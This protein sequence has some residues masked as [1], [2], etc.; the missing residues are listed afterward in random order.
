MGRP[1]AVVRMTYAEYLAAE[2]AADVRHEYL[3][4]DVWAM[5][6]G[7]IEHGGLAVALARAGHR[8]TLV[9]ADESSQIADLFGM[10]AT[11]GLTEVLRGRLEMRKAIQSV[12]DLPD[13]ALVAAGH[14]LDSEIDELI[15]RRATGREV[16]TAAAARGFRTLADDAISRVLMGQTSLEEISRV[17]DLTDRVI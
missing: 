13:L 4:G 6:G 16:R 5:A 15:A 17:V 11:D 8:T 1:A 10:P 2:A 3:A 7:T 12:P 9:V 14:G